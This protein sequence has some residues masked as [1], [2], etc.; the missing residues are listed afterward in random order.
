MT[1]YVIFYP[2]QTKKQPYKFMTVFLGFPKL[3]LVIGSWY[4]THEVVSDTRF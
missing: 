2:I 3:E 1:T 4:I